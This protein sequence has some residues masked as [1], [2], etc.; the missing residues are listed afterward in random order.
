M[1]KTFQLE[2]SHR[3]FKLSFTSF[4]FRYIYSC[5]WDCQ[6]KL[7]DLWHIEAWAKKKKRNQFCLSFGYVTKKMADHCYL[8]C[9]VLISRCTR[10]ELRFRAT[11]LI[12]LEYFK[13]KGMSHT[14]CNLYIVHPWISAFVCCAINIFFRVGSFVTKQ[15]LLEC[16]K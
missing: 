4:K 6:D 13:L 16:R 14:F 5:V 11:V 3:T 7:Q 12:N 1:C 9:V 2:R 15:L 8:F 10:K